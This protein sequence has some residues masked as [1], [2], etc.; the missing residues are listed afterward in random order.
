MD[1]LPSWAYYVLRVSGMP[2]TPESTLVS[3]AKSRAYEARVADTPFQAKTL[4][5]GVGTG[6]ICGRS[7]S[8]QRHLICR[9]ST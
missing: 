2:D 4:N 5:F 3:G 8:R 9:K 7:R 6:E 1:M